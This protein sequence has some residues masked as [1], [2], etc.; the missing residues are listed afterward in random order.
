[1]I[2]SY[3][4]LKGEKKMKT[5]QVQI[6]DHNVNSDWWKKII[7]YFVKPGDEIEIRCWNEEKEEIKKA[8]SY[9]RP[10]QIESNF[11]TAIKGI[12]TEQMIKEFLTLPE[13]VDKVVYNKMT[14]FFT[15]L[16][17]NKISSEHYGTELY[18]FNVHDDEVEVFKKIMTPYWEKFSISIEEQSRNDK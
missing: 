7:Q 14:E 17:E 8:M 11:Q 3:A 5:I 9:G 12:V 4:T 15:I 13:P 1:M 18:L 16:V 10:I 2:F 6:L